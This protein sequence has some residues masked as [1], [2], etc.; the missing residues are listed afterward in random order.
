MTAGLCSILKE[1]SRESQSPRLNTNEEQWDHFGLLWSPY[2]SSWN[3]IRKRPFSR[4]VGSTG[5]GLE[6]GS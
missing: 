5:R 2:T 4:T 6:M 1:L 3:S